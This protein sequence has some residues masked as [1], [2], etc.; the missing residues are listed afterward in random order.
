MFSAL[1]R[2]QVTLK[3]LF[4][5]QLR[6]LKNQRVLKQHSFQL[7]GTIINNNK[8]PDNCAYIMQGK[9]VL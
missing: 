7:N 8:L 3:R 5:T 9:H 6:A 4:I 2:L 1:P